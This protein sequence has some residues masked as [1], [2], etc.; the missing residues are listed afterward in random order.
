MTAVSGKSH[1]QLA[2]DRK[3]EFIAARNVYITI[4][5]LFVS[6]CTIAVIVTSQ[7]EAAKTGFHPITTK[8]PMSFID[9]TYMYDKTK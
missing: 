5:V 3:A 7:M 8:A 2:A 6:I 9:R 4:I 1:D